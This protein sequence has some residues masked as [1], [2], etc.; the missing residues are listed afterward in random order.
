MLVF[1]LNEITP[2]LDGGLHYGVTK[3]WA[4]ALRA[5]ENGELACEGLQGPDCDFPVKNTIGLPFAN[6]PPP[7]DHKLK[8]AR[9]FFSERF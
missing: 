6:P 8:S 5:H 2:W 1:Q 3:A 7:A 9:R 4:D